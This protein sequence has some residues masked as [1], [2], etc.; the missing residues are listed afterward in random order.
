MHVH[1]GGG[2]VFAYLQA[3]DP[4]PIAILRRPLIVFPRSPPAATD[5]H[6]SLASAQLG[7]PPPMPQHSQHPWQPF[8]MP[9]APVAPPSALPAAPPQ[10]IGYAPGGWCPMPNYYPHPRNRIQSV[11]LRAHGHPISR[12]TWGPYGHGDED[13]ETAKPDK[14]T[15]RD[16][17]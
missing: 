5:V 11:T 8:P 9:T 15:G 6:P 7:P 2:G 14:F 1:A 10:N 13:S 12:T 3:D 16:P 17:A 4:Q